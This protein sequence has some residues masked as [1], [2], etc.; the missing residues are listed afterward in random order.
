MP[1][2]SKYLLIDFIIGL[3]SMG[4]AM[5]TNLQKTL[6]YRGLPPLKFYNRTA[7][8]GQTLQERGAQQCGSISDVVQQSD[9][10]YISVSELNRD[11]FWLIK[12]Y[13]QQFPLMLA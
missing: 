1:L 8:R 13:L 6:Q 3:G 12:L 2:K 10:I 11:D 7:S 9:W 5:A 4:L